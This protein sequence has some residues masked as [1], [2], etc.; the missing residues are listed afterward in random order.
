M[1]GY[2]DTQVDK[3]W[4]NDYQGY[5]SIMRVT[6]N[7]ESFGQ[8]IDQAAAATNDFMEIL[9]YVGP[10]IE[11]FCLDLEDLVYTEEEADDTILKPFSSNAVDHILAA[12]PSVQTLS[13]QQTRF[14]D[15]AENGPLHM[16]LN[17]LVVSDSS[18]FEE[19]FLIR[20]SAR[21]PN[22][23]EVKLEIE[24]KEIL[25]AS[26]F[27]YIVMPFSKLNSLKVEVKMSEVDD[28]DIDINMEERNNELEKG[29]DLN[30]KLKLGD[31]SPTTGTTQFYHCHVSH[32]DATTRGT[33][34]QQPYRLN[35]THTCDAICQHGDA[36]MIVRNSQSFL[37]LSS[38]LNTFVLNV[39]GENYTR[40]KFVLNPASL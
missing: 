36:D 4:S 32:D 16:N 33:T 35:L 26:G 27:Y 31:G 28:Y 22:L 2:E 3:S 8:Q 15:S 17:K 39:D 38:S 29:E 13:I 9:K 37:S 7:K 21:A 24:K 19:C 10:Y 25:S 1:H 20:L 5:H 34:A 14:I 30:L 18:Q 23:Q 6:K 11:I 40:N 12:C